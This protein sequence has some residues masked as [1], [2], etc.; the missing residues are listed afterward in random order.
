MADMGVWQPSPQ[1]QDTRTG[2]QSMRRVLI[3]CAVIGLCVSVRLVA[4]S[5]AGYRANIGKT[6]LNANGT[7]IGRI[8]DVT[9]MN[10][11]LVYKVEREG[12]IIS[13]PAGTTIVKNVA[14]NPVKPAEGSKPA[15]V[16]VARPEGN[17]DPL[18]ER[19]AIDFREE[20]ARHQSTL[21]AL[22][23]TPKGIS[24]RW[25]SLKCDYFESELIDLLLSIKRTQK[26]SPAIIGVHSCRGKARPFAVTGETFHQ[27]RTGEIDEAKVLAAVK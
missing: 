12:K 25:T 19:T 21:Q 20:L 22:V 6:A 17:I 18:L 2:A 16:P 26:A 1:D 15:K 23:I 11:V 24:A 13:S 4:Q 3:V 10:G 14:A 27:Y 8:V 5:E 9:M 7:E